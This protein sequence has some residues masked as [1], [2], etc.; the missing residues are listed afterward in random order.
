MAKYMS[1]VPPSP[2]PK[3]KKQ[4]M[5]TGIMGSSPSQRKKSNM[6]YVKSVAKIAV[7]PFNVV[8]A[9]RKA[10]S[11]S[12]AKKAKFSPTAKRVSSRIADSSRKTKQ[13]QSIAMDKVKSVKST[14]AD[15]KRKTAQG[16]TYPPSKKAP[17]SY[18]LG[19]TPSQKKKKQG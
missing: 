4:S 7:D 12:A 13:A 17:S 2:K 18:A 1:Q 3:P 16:K 11:P 19:L 9:L 5:N 8:G 6:D 14:S 10:V 15:S